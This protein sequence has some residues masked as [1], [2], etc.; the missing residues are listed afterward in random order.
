MHEQ[1]KS[2]SVRG[3]IGFLQPLPARRSDM[4]RFEFAV[5]VCL[6]VVARSAAQTQPAIDPNEGIKHIAWKDAGSAVGQTVFVSGKIMNVGK[7]ERIAFLNFED[8]R[9]PGFV[10]VIFSDNWGKFPEDIRK[11]YNGKVVEIRG[12]VTL[13]QNRPQMVVTRPEQIT[14]LDA[15][16]ATEKLDD[17]QVETWS[18]DPNKLV[19]CT[20]NS[21]NLFD[22][23]DDPY[24]NDE[25][26]R[27]KPREELEKL[28]ETLRKVNADVVVLEE[29]E[30][31]GY[32]ERFVKL[33]L[34]DMGYNHIVHF[35]GNDLRGIDVALLSRAPIGEVTSRR[36]LEFKGPDGIVRSFQRDVPAITV[37]PKM[38]APL[39]IWP[40]HLKSKA[41]S[42]ETSEPIRLGEAAELRRLLDAE[43]ATNPH[44]RI[45]VMGDFNDTRDS[46]SL[47][48]IFGSGAN[49]M[50]APEVKETA[51]SIPDPEF[52]NGRP[53][54]DFI[55][56][57]PAMKAVY[58]EDSCQTR[59]AP[60]EYDGSDHD[61]QWAVF[62]LQ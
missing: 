52:P 17:K 11:A 49:A 42:A 38:G 45:I 1:L 62:E 54:I 31:R 22:D 26:T 55:A 37:I 36:H 28:A 7:T 15:M 5:C 61:P 3:R 53:P 25:G 8:K 50:W 19:V 57:S 41:D 2:R 29:V 59:R 40:V 33:F 51:D 27:A 35:D 60:A 56:L 24:T 14:I 16:P 4:H 10:A 9:P 20:F 18:A 44:A 58:V 6:L 13:Y 39:E 21:L 46:K 43:F 34:G 32:L 12:L 47:G 48:I 30:N 23:V